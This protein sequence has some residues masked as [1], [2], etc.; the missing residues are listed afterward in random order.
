MRLSSSNGLLISDKLVV[1]LEVA[2]LSSEL[3]FDAAIH[4]WFCIHGINAWL[5]ISV[6]LD[7]SVGWNSVSSS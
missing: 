6:Q 2:Q 1:K 3:P 5:L 7:L 4:D